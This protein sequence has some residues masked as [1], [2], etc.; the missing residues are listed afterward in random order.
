MARRLNLTVMTL[1]FLRRPALACSAAALLA[2]ANVAAAGVRQHVASGIAFSVS[3]G[4]IDFGKNLVLSGTI[5]THAAGQQVELLNQACGFTEPVTL[6]TV[7][8]G[9]GGKFHF[10]LQPMLKTQYTARWNER[11]SG[12]RT[13]GVRPQVT[14]AKLSGNRYLVSASVGG[15][16]FFTGKPALLQR[17]AGSRWVTVASTTLKQAS[18]DTALV[19]VSSGTVAAS[20]ARGSTVRAAIAQSAVGSCYLPSTSAPLVL[21]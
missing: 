21:P 8:T 14:L 12:G 17:R 15:G 11:T 9:A 19:A 5:P 10:T 3:A 6:A 20:V 7:R 4:K 13:I 18:D 1:G 2:S 16:Q